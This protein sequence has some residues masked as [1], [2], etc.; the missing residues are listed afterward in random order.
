MSSRYVGGDLE[1]AMSFYDSQ[2][3]A[4]FSGRRRRHSSPFN[5]C[6]EK[7]E[8]EK[9]PSEAHENES[10]KFDSRFLS[11]DPAGSAE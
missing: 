1:N 10:D 2:L 8:E 3:R 9:R 6:K 7:E 11:S 5:C 4:F